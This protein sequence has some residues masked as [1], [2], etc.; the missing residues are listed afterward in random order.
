MLYTFF[1][2]HIGFITA[3][4]Q[5]IKPKYGIK[6]NSF[7]QNE[8]KLANVAGGHTCYKL[9][10]INKYPA[11]HGT[12]SGLCEPYV[13]VDQLLKHFVIICDGFACSK[14]RGIGWMSW[15]CKENIDICITITFH[16][17]LWQY[18]WFYRIIGLCSGRTRLK[19]NVWIVGF[20]IVVY[21]EC[22][23]LI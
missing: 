7:Y 3:R 18:E 21:V 5:T 12:I 4:K 16:R 20:C 10:T 23:Y 1:I 19:P 2:I 14:H 8:W 15:Y 17:G 11:I 6:L 13:D 9:H 22:I